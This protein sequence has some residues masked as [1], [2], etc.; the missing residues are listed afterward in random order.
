ME[1]ASKALYIAG[2][3]IIA[4]LVLSLFVYL[5]ALGARF[6]GDYEGRKKQEQ[7]EQFNSKFQLYLSEGK[8]TTISDIITV[9]NLVYNINK[10][11]NFS[12][13]HYSYN[14]NGSVILEVN[15][16]GTKLKMEPTED[17]KANN[18]FKCSNNNEHQNHS[19]ST[20]VSFY[21]LMGKD[22]EDIGELGIAV[23]HTGK[24]IESKLT[25]QD[26]YNKAIRVFK[27]YFKVENIT[28]NDAT[29]L[30]D[31]IRFTAEE[32]SGYAALEE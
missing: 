5:F 7:L 11:S 32:T 21:D 26:G 27:Y 17:M 18:F 19:G 14:R 15:I 16:F 25:K 20:Y 8:T 6:N 9:A 10:Q 31:S 4:L 23:S 30:V 13:N 24:L 29:H 3:V 12:L 22:M 2:A 28:Y 1:N